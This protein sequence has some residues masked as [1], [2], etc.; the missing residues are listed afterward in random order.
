MNTRLFY[1]TL[2]YDVVLVVVLGG[3]GLSGGRGGVRNVIIGTLFVGTLMT[4][5]TIMNLSYTTQNLIKS[6]V[7]LIALVADTLAKSS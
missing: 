6:F 1:T 7:M 4:G 5:M 2:V 3:I